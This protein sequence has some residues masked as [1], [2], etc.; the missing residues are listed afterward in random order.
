MRYFLLFLLLL[1]SAIAFPPSVEL[2]ISDIVD[3]PYRKYQEV[4]WCGEAGIQSAIGTYGVYIPQK[5]IHGIA[6]PKNRDLYAQDIPTTLNRLGFGFEFYPLEKPKYSHFITWI[7]GFLSHKIPVLF[8]VH[9]YPDHTEGDLSH[10]MLAIGYTKDALLFNSNSKEGKERKSFKGLYTKK[11]YSFVNDS[12]TFFGVA[13]GKTLYSEDAGEVQLHIVK[14]SPKEVEILVVAKGL[15]K[16]ESLYRYGLEYDKSKE[17]LVPI[18]E[19]KK[20]LFSY[21]NTQI[22]ERIERD[23]AYVYMKKILFK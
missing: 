15:D 14:D 19:G 21:P 6:E 2:N 17:R 1:K 9:I 10:F 16:G 22:R 23:K 13:I 12:Q 20:R 7:K 5:I 18:K 4:G 8:G 11:G 3:D